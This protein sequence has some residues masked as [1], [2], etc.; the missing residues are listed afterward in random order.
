LAL[1]LVL[2]VAGALSGAAATLEHYLQGIEPAEFIPGAASF[3]PLEGD[4]PLAPVLNDA[5]EP[6]GWAFLNTDLTS[7]VGYSG[8]PIHIVVGIDAD[9]TV[10]GLKIVEHH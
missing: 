2:T 4:P 8:K 10:H 6:I 9:G 3:G 1:A 7:S 5:G